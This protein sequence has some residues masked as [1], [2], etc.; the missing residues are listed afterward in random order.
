MWLC[1]RLPKLV[2]SIRLDRLRQTKVIRLR[3]MIILPILLCSFSENS[4]Y[5]GYRYWHTILNE[6]TGVYLVEQINSDFQVVKTSQYQI[7]LIDEYEIH[8]VQLTSIIFDDDPS[9]VELIVR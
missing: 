1:R 3:R 4:A 9:T 5:L 6:E 2:Y 7:P 8:T